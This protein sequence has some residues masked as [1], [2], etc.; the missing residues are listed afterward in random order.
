[1]PGGMTDKNDWRLQRNEDKYLKGLTLAHK[2]WHSSRPGWNHDHWEFCWA[3]I[4][5]LDMP[6]AL[7][8]GWT[9][10]D[11]YRWIC[12]T[13]FQDFRKDFQW[14]IVETRSD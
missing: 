5:G 10:P 11:E 14:V 3:E 8:E 1:M 13:C 4:A 6:D 12:D 7:H 9:A 2:P